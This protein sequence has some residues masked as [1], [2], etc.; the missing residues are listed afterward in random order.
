MYFS[1]QLREGLRVLCA[2]CLMVIT[3]SVLCASE[4]YTA[5]IIDAPTAHIDEY[6]GYTASFRFY[7]EGGILSRLSF[8]VLNRVNIGFSW[9]LEEVVGSEIIDVNKPTLNLKIRFWDGTILFPA[10]AFGYDGQGYFFDETLDEYVQREKGVFLAATQE[11]FLPKLELTAGMNIFDFT[12]DTVYGFGGLTY[13]VYPVS[14][15]AECDNIHEAEFNR[16]NVGISLMLGS[17]VSVDLLG[18]DIGAKYREAERVVRINYQ[19][20]F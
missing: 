10:L 20:S 9:D 15:L 8:G 3:G 7:S 5:A 19:G 2:C 12:E 18:R 6:G 4:E 14:L 13:T 1:K 16:I 11:L 17:S